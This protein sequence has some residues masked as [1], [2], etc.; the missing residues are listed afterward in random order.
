MSTGWKPVGLLLLLLL[1][2]LCISATSLFN[3]AIPVNFAD[4]IDTFYSDDKSLSQTV[5]FEIRLPRILLAALVGAGLGVSGAVIQGLFRNP[6]ADPG[7]IGVSGGAALGAAAILVLGA[8]FAA[9]AAI[10]LNFVLPIAAFVGGLVVTLLVLAFSWSGRSVSITALLLVGLAINTMATG[11]IGIL[12]ALSDH[13]S[14]RNL[15]FW[16]LG[17]MASADLEKVLIAALVIVPALCVLLRDAKNLDC[18]LIGEPSARALGI[19]VTGLKFR[20]V[21]L[22]ALI[23]GCSVAFTG[24]IGFIG[25]IVPNLL[26]FVV[27]PLH[28]WLL[29]ASAIFGALILVTADLLARSLWFPREMPI[30]VLTSLIGGPIFIFLIAFQRKKGLL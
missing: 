22:S 12:T 24:M 5:I 2:L 17:S 26:R 1:G 14:L 7:L 21:L 25:L 29:P 27:G 11:G 4:L 19:Q 18:L 23:V 9:L 15:T 20:L 28:R 3:G 6:L 8:Q 16:L 30:G 10:P 13:E